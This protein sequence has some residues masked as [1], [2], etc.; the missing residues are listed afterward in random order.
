MPG[1]KP[2]ALPLGDAPNHSAN[3][4]SAEGNSIEEVLHVSTLRHCIEA[5]ASADILP[6]SMQAGR[7]RSQGHTDLPA[8]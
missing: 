4:D 6:T 3:E 1:P 7:L 2:G 8:S 5:A